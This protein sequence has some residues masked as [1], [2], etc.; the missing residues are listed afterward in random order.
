MYH[1]LA[2]LRS[3]VPQV[4]A[5]ARNALYTRYT[6]SDWASTQR[7]HY[8]TADKFRQLS[9]SLRTD[10]NRLA[11]EVDD[12]TR[13]AQDESGKKLGERVS[14]IE[15]WRYR[16]AQQTSEDQLFTSICVTTCVCSNELN[17]E[18]DA[19]VTETNQLAE[20]KRQV[21]RALLE[22]ENPLHIAQECLFTREKR[23]GIDLVHDDTERELLKV[24]ASC[25]VSIPYNDYTSLRADRPAAIDPFCNE[26]RRRWTR[27]N[28][29]RTSCDRPSIAPTR[30]SR[31]PSIIPA[32]TDAPAGKRVCCC[33][34][35]EPRRSARAREGRGR[36]VLGEHTGRAEPPAQQHLSRHRAASGRRERR[37]HV[38]RELTLS[39]LRPPLTHTDR[40]HCQ[41]HFHLLP[42]LVARSAE[43]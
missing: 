12:Q 10:S 14:D 11:R 41:L 8:L 21:E 30:S 36:Q 22:T 7:Q 1:T 4:F 43:C 3:Q 34:Q 31:T 42:S 28:A 5:S 17:H 29:A 25:F 38:R 33:S 20:A 35:A 37:Q 23:Q 24:R 15:F 40:C 6:P 18:T 9:E 2:S 27:S 26:L 13:A 19:Q 32:R 16:F 39:I